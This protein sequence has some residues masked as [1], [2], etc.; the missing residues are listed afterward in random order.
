[1]LRKYGRKFRDGVCKRVIGKRWL[2]QEQYI[3]VKSIDEMLDIM[4][5]RNGLWTEA[6]LLNA[7]EWDQCRKKARLLLEM[8]E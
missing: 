1:M 5:E 8:L 6:A 7:E 2:T 3:I 4:S